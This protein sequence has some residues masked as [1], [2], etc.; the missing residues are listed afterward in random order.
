[1]PRWL[2]GVVFALAFALTVAM[3]FYTDSAWEDWYITYRA[4]QNLAAGNGLV[5][6]PGERVHT[7]TSPL[8]VL[9]PAGFAYAVG[10]EDEGLVLWLYRILNALVVG[11]AAVLLLWL[12][13]RLAMGLWPVL[14]LLGLFLLDAK[15]LIFS[16]NGME[17]AYLVFFIAMA[18]F[19]LHGDLRRR[20][21]WLGL[22]WAGLMWTRPDGCIYIAAI[23]L[24][25]LIFCPA[26]PGVASRR[27]YLVLYVKAALVTTALYLPWFAWAWW[28]YGSPVPN[29]ILAKGLRFSQDDPPGYLYHTLIFPYL[30]TYHGR[31]ADLIF[32]QPYLNYFNDG[33]AW[34]GYVS[35]VL[36]SLAIFQ[37]ILPLGLSREARAAS[38][39]A[40]L[41]LFYMV[42]IVPTHYPWYIPGFA[43]LVYWALA[44]G[45]QDWQGRAAPAKGRGRLAPAAVAAVLLFAAGVSVATVHQ[46]ESFQRVVD[47]GL[48]APLGEWLRQNADSPQDTVFIEC[49]GY[50][51]YYSELKMYDFPG[52]SSPEMVAARKELQSDNWAE[53]ISYLKPDWVV[54]RDFEIDVINASDPTVLS[55]Q[56]TLAKRFDEREVVRSIPW[57]PGRD[58]LERD[59]NFF[60]F[61]RRP[62]A[63]V[64]GGE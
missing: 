64:T 35:R 42:V 27:D 52:L 40:M 56:Y 10:P 6:S 2:Y 21:L 13:S 20:F 16:I 36:V 59:D 4:S 31:A 3:A 23:G 5:F 57:V 28:Y 62:E 54:V 9:I 46:M 50:V 15:M 49:L 11:A 60:I 19:C 47:R 45:L 25:W 8:G 48:R 26:I 39:T 53:L 30:V 55:N 33:I 51:G 18:L 14:L 43:L 17:T 22:A 29:T 38:L 44:R 58:M 37:W 63:G 34:T 12:A 32:T 1:M 7:F 61:A 24:G 41:A